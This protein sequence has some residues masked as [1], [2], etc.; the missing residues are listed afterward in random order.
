MKLQSI[1]WIL[2]AVGCASLAACAKPEEAPPPTA[3]T[4]TTSPLILP[5]SL[6]AVM[7]A[8]VDHASDPIW[9]DAYEPPKTDAG[10]RDLE[11]HANQMAVYGKVIQLAGTGPN[12]A[13]W[14]QDE[15]WKRFAN[16][17]SAAGMSALSA[18]KSKD[19]AALNVAGDKLVEA[20]ES[21]HKMFKPDLPSMGL[22]HKPDYPPGYKSEE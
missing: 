17:M 10:W 2:A 3:Q 8:M 4:S 16:D 6:N 19:V 22:Y 5:V 21:C 15:N 7:V 9:L 20:C 12:D 13:D 11:Y 18:A 14:V 1:K